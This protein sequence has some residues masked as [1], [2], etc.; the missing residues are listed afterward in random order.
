MVT[1]VADRIGL[2]HS[3]MKEWESNWRLCKV[4]NISSSPVSNNLNSWIVMLLRSKIC[5]VIFGVKGNMWEVDDMIY[6]KLLMIQLFGVKV[7]KINTKML[8]QWHA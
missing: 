4:S 6:G 5:L 3:L 8:A 2:F 1:V 7:Q